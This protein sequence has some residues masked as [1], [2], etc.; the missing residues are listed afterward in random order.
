MLHKT[1]V[2]IG[3]RQG[4]WTPW[5][6]SD[7]AKH[8]AAAANNASE[9]ALRAA[10]NLIMPIMG[11]Y[12]PVKTRQAALYEIGRTFTVPWSENL[13]LLPNTASLRFFDAFGKGKQAVEDAAEAFFP[14]YEK[15][16]NDL[17]L[18]ASLNVS[19]LGT[20]LN[21]NDYPH[22]DRVRAKFYVKLDVMSVPESGD[23]RVE[24]FTQEEQ[25]RFVELGRQSVTDSMARIVTSHMQRLHE[26]VQAMAEVLQGNTKFHNTLLSN[27]RDTVRLVRD[28]NVTNNQGVINL[29]ELC[30][31]ELLT[32]S[33]DVLLEN[34]NAR[35]SVAEQARILSQAMSGIIE[36]INPDGE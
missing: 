8:D 27:L 2:L 34:V 7:K 3:I 12:K 24:G 25:D 33:R 29:C 19:G 15:F 18:N 22:P 32:H 16:F 11:V 31:K 20:L 30:E 36:Q 9:A 10:K 23:I 13:R 28:L 1:S 21:I 14:V 17:S 5:R 4:F 26:R 35:Q 6:Q